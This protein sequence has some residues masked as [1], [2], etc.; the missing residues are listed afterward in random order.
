MAKKDILIFMSDQHTPHVSGYFGNNADTPN[1]DA[2]AK[3]GTNFSCCYSSCP[4]CVPARMS[5]MSGQYAKKT[6]VYIVDVV[7]SLA[8]QSVGTGGTVDLLS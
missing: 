2:L 1:M 7:R 3:N 5:M 6:G 8:F 4:L